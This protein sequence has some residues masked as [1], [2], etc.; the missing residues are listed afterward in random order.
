MSDWQPDRLLPG[1][2]A[3]TLQQTPDYDGVVVATLVRQR[4]ASAPRGAALYVH[5]FSDYFFQRHMAQRFGAE[6]YAFYALDLRKH[7]RSLLPEQHPNFCKSVSEYYADLDAALEAIGEPALLCGH[8]TGGLV[9]SL[10]AHEGAR[11]EALRGVWLNSAFFDWRVESWRRPQ[12]HVAAATGRFMPFLNNPDPFPPDYQQALL[13]EWEFDIA[14]KP[15][16]GFPV[17]YG[18]I[19]A[20]AD[21][22]EKV[23]RGLDIRCPV[24]SMHSDESDVVLDWRS[25]AKWSRGLGRQVSVLSFPGAWHDL[26]CSPGAIR[27]AVFSALF[28]WAERAVE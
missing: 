10:Y 27:E 18:W 16:R 21:A 5:G 19:G 22:H 25:I 2:E 7:G 9:A 4:A 8:S 6:G 17:Y 24:L 11:R 13:E 14:L 3:L 26:I 23:H 1:F 15:L 12:L 28:S 20:I